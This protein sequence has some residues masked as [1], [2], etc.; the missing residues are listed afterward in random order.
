MRGD[1]WLMRRG[2]VWYYCGYVAGKKFR[3]STHERDRETAERI[4]R[5][6][7][8]PGMNAARGAV[9]RLRRARWAGELSGAEV[10]VLRSP[11]VYAWLRG[12]QVLYVGKGETGFNRPL[13]PSHHQLGMMLPTDTLRLWACDTAAEACELEV[14]LIRQLRPVLNKETVCAKRK[15]PTR[16]RMG[17]VVPAN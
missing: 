3:I 8:L 4:V 10:L 12:E 11:L 1:G 7:G 5:R 2:E 17:P 14:H 16:A 6:R 9:E 15:G 13:S